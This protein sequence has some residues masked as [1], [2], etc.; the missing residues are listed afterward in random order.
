MYIYTNVARGLIEK[1]DGK[2]L[3]Y[4]QNSWG[5][6][7]KGPEYNQGIAGPEA[8][9]LQWCEINCINA[10]CFIGIYS[11]YELNREKVN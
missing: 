5:L 7:L 11:D 8:D 10:I 3:K 2:K 1:D 9:L 4:L 6:D